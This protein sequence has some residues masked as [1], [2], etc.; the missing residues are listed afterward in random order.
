MIVEDK[1]ERECRREVC[2]AS[3]VVFCG[4]EEE[5]GGDE[6]PAVVRRVRF[7]SWSGGSGEVSTLHDDGERW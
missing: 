1:L 6:E 3:P 5:E 2:H 7:G 4:R